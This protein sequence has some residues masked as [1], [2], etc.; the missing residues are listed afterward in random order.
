[1]VWRSRTVQVHV[2][3]VE[4]RRWLGARGQGHRIQLV[5]RVAQTHAGPQGPLAEALVFAEG[6][7]RGERLATVF[8]L[9]LLA[10]VRVHSFMAAKVRELCVRL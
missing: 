9:D 7:D 2:G 1:M 8:A 3:R 6:S 10:T 4:V 5:L